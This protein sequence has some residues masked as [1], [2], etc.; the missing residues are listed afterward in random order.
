M[1]EDDRKKAMLL[2]RCS[3]SASLMARTAGVLMSG[4]GKRSCLGVPEPYMPSSSTCGTMPGQISA[5]IHEPE[6]SAP[7]DFY[8]Q[9]SLHWRECS[10]H[11]RHRC[12]GC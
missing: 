9:S 4:T 12:R 3:S 8:W 1:P 10:A 6:D 5:E 11:S 7:E 2:L